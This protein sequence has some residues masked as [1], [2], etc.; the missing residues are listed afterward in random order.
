MQSISCPECGESIPANSESCPECGFPISKLI[1]CEECN[2]FIS[3]NSESCP[4]CGFPQALRSKRK[5][6]HE[7]LKEEKERKESVDLIRDTE[8]AERELASELLRDTEEAEKK[9]ASAN[10][11]KR[12]TADSRSKKV[13]QG[14]KNPKNIVEGLGNIGGAE[15]IGDFNPIK[16]FGGV[17]KRY[18]E[19]E[20]VKNIFVGT[21]GTTPS[22]KEISTKYPQPWIFSRLIVVA[23]VIFYAFKFAY[24][25][26]P[27]PMY[28]P[29]LIITGSFGIPLSTLVLF[30]ELNIRRNIPIWTIAKLFLAGAVLSLFINQVFFENTLTFLG[31][32]GA[33]AAAVT[34]EPA[35]LLALVVLARGK[36]RY[37]YILNGL[38]LGAAVGCGFAAFES[39]G[40]AY[41]NT[42]YY[43]VF[44]DVIT[45]R[46]ILS[47]FAHI[48]WTAIAGAALWR[49]KKSGNFLQLSLPFLGIYEKIKFKEVVVVLK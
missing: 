28:I 11:E 36:K 2:A 9:A 1:I 25:Q 44:F 49:V 41:N 32:A 3:I 4:E 34:E 24:D 42:K 47:P 39:A 26:S 16:F 8:E 17:P 33:S 18:S 23:L 15:G 12:R 7:D 20:F 45:I 43:K 10:Y 29:A 38:L 5:L 31:W 40:Y 48:V 37:P 22:I 27:N 30:L 6:S 21:E 35:K 19:E 14:N 13:G 46:G